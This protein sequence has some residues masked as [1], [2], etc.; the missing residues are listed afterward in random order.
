MVIDLS[1]HSSN[2][3]SVR[4][5]AL[6]NAVDTSPLTQPLPSLAFVPAGTATTMP[7]LQK[8]GTIFLLFPSFKTK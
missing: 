7:S 2:V 3:S 5:D 4:G 6:V 1:N 8:L